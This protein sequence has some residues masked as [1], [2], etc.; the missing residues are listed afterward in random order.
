MVTKTV[1]ITVHLV[2]KQHKNKRKGGTG[3]DRYESEALLSPTDREF[4]DISNG[5]PR[6]QDTLC[7][8]TGGPIEEY[9]TSSYISTSDSPWLTRVNEWCDAILDNDSKR[10]I[11]SIKIA[12]WPN[13]PPGIGYSEHQITGLVG[14]VT[15][16]DTSVHTVPEGILAY[17]RVK[18]EALSYHDNFPSWWR[19][20]QI[21]NDPLALE[22]IYIAGQEGHVLYDFYQG[23]LWRTQDGLHR[24]ETRVYLARKDDT[25]TAANDVTPRCLLSDKSANKFVNTWISNEGRGR[26][27]KISARD[28]LRTEARA[29]K[30]EFKDT[31]IADKAEA[32]LL[33]DNEEHQCFRVDAENN[34]LVTS[35]KNK[36]D[37]DEPVPGCESGIT[38]QQQ[39]KLELDLDLLKD[40]PLCLINQCTHEED[41]EREKCIK[42]LPEPDYAKPAFRTKNGP[43]KAKT[44]KFVLNTSDV[45]CKVVHEHVIDL[46]QEPAAEQ[47]GK[48]TIGCHHAKTTADKN[49]GIKAEDSLIELRKRRQYSCLG[50]EQLHCLIKRCKC[51]DHVDL[52]TVPERTKEED[53]RDDGF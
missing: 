29:L 37:H 51:C 48:P 7:I 41:N 1:L 12:H 9:I 23:T 47:E 42:S 38:P 14:R 11:Q 39:A 18:L 25:F 20:D 26:V 16:G 53:D 6:K 27:K 34:V 33:D 49:N 10:Q 21:L 2:D 13:F 44:Y 32:W 46:T 50:C 24:V 19:Y 43:K 35:L 31:V 4:G 8:K 28:K 30:D 45:K 52:S 22:T 17:A 3:G 36:T 40:W 5:E 15:D